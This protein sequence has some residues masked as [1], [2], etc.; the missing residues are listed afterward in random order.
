M[1]RGAWQAIV[2]VGRVTKMHTLLRT[3]IYTGVSK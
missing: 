2:Q 3:Y 1:D